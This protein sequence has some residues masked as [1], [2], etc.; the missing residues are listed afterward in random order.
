M[1]I[2]GNNSPCTKR[3]NTSCGT[4][5]AK[6]MIS[7]GTTIANAA[8]VIRRLR[9]RTSASAPVN[10]AVSA[11]AAVPAVISALIVAGADAEFAR[12]LGQQRLRRI[13]IDEG[14]EAR[15][16]NGERAEIQG[17][18]A[19]WARRRAKASLRSECVARPGA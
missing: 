4:L 1:K 12:Q 10:G 13:K 18:A 16:G 3:Q 17:H 14:G 19:L 9:P 2:G 11:I 6:A 8:A 7:V 15:R 5:V